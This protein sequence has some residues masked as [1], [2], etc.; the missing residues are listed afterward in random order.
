MPEPALIVRVAALEQQLQAVSRTNATLSGQVADLTAE[1]T[2]LHTRVD[3]EVVGLKQQLKEVSDTNAI[4]SGQV[5]DL[6]AELTA[7]HTRVDLEVA[8]LK[9]QLN[10]VSDANA[11]LSSQ[12]ADL[13]DKVRTLLDKPVNPEVAA[14]ETKLAEMDVK[15]QLIQKELA[16]ITGAPPSC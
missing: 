9:Q 5:A 14:V 7:L 1:L 16:S 11:T 8:G 2:A 15:M 3:F 12:V 13:T 6:T 10:E 4:L